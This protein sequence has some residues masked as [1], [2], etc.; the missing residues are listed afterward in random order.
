MSAVEFVR[1]FK[2]GDKV[3]FIYDLYSRKK[4]FVDFYKIFL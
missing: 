2:C 1:Y 3:E 4:G